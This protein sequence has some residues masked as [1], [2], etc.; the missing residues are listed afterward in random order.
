MLEFEIYLCLS[1][2]IGILAIVIG[3]IFHSMGKDEI[4]QIFFFFCIGNFST[5]AIV[6]IIMALVHFVNQKGG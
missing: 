6:S 4:S 3:W 1:S 2:I 5:L